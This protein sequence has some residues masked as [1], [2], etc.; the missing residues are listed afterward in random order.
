MR[1]SCGNNR[2]F[3]IEILR[4]TSLAA[5]LLFAGFL[6]QESLAHRWAMR[7]RSLTESLA[8]A[9]F[10][11]QSSLKPAVSVVGQLL[12]NVRGR[13]SLPF[14]WAYSECTATVKHRS[15]CAVVQ[16][17]EQSC[18]RVSAMI[19]ACSHARRKRI[20]SMRRRILMSIC[21]S[22]ITTVRTV[23]RLVSGTDWERKR[24]VCGIPFNGMS[25]CNFVKI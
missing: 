5:S 3:I 4:R 2:W 8:V 9:A 1:H 7:Q 20:W 12:T 16:A 15:F 21:V 19:R 22:E 10:L 23:K 17:S 13:A 6:R 24:L 18:T 14:S 25:S 11:R